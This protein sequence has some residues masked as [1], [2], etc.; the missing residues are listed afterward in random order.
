VRLTPPTEKRR[1]KEKAVAQ[2]ADSAGAGNSGGTL[3]SDA[4]GAGI[5]TLDI[6]YAPLCSQHDVQYLMKMAQDIDQRY[7]TPLG[8]D[9]KA[10]AAKLAELRASQLAVIAP[11]RVDYRFRALSP[12]NQMCWVTAIRWLTLGCPDT[13]RPKPIPHASLVRAELVRASNNIA[14]LDLP[15][16]R[17]TRLI[18]G[19]Y[20]RQAVGGHLPTRRW[21]AYA[22]FNIEL[23]AMANTKAGLKNKETRRGN[24]HGVYLA[25]V[26]G[27]SFHRTLNRL[28]LLHLGK[29]K[30]L[31]YHEHA[32]E[33]ELETNSVSLHIIKAVLQWWV[34]RKRWG[35]PQGGKK[36]PK[37]PIW[38]TNEA[39]YLQASEAVCVARLRSL[40]VLFAEVMKRKPVGY[41]LP[42]QQTQN[43]HKAGKRVKTKTFEAER[44]AAEGEV[45]VD[46]ARIETVFK[47]LDSSGSGE[48]N[49]QKIRAGVQVLMGPSIPVEL[50][51]RMVE[52][53]DTD[54]AGVVDLPQFIRGFTLIAQEALGQE[55]GLMDEGS[56]EGDSDLED[57]DTDIKELQRKYGRD[58]D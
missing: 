40:R 8:K 9:K 53:I 47:D 1:F 36:F 30:C 35:K 23:H 15:V 33:Y 48:L 32:A 42:G 55:D 22:I 51:S 7:T 49:E 14:L 39:L 10:D 3:A 16:S 25:D 41:E 12:G 38:S 2:D 4:N 50:E 5:V 58:E 20:K 18:R 6:L 21:V 46:V 29:R 26:R 13:R 34:N 31:S 52:M 57:L 44:A 37:L 24:A 11:K 54:Q 19:L 17:L 28:V 27:L 56:G 43:T 45:Q